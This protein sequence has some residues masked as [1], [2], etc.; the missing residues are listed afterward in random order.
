MISLITVMAPCVPLT[1]CFDV[2]GRKGRPD[3]I[4]EIENPCATLNGL[5]ELE[6]KKR[7]VLEDNPAG[8]LVLEVL[9]LLRED[10]DRLFL[11]PLGA[12]G[13][14]EDVGVLQVRRDID[15]ANGN[16]GSLEFDL[17]PDDDAKLTLD[18]FTDPKQTKTH[19]G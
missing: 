18:Q 14:D 5:I 7:R 13:A 16:K 8:E 15:G 10:L 6:M 4:E 1:L 12:D 9:T 17:T 2:I 19:D 11:L 3:L